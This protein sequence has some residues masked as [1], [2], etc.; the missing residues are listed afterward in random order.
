MVGNRQVSL[1]T[2]KR[3]FPEL[4]VTDEAP[5]TLAAR[6]EVIQI[7][8]ED[9]L[10]EWVRTVIETHP[11]ERS[12]FREGESKLMDF[13]MGRVMKT[14]RGKANPKRVQQMLLEELGR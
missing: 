4:A 2:A 7:D 13:F 12:R 8:D 11:D 3:L 5:E 14:S 1:Q 9:Q 10:S 6:L